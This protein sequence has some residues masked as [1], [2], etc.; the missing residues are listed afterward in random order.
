ME[1]RKTKGKFTIKRS[2]IP[3]L[4]NRNIFKRYMEAIR[5]VLDQVR[6][7]SLSEIQAMINS[8]E[9]SNMLNEDVKCFLI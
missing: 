8:A 2:Q 9:E 1:G 3:T 5:A 6:G 7:L 4:F